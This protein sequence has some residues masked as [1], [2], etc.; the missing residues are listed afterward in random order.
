VVTDRKSDPDMSK[1][2]ERYIKGGR[3]NPAVRDELLRAY[4]FIV[5]IIANKLI[6]KLPYWVEVER[7]DLVSAGCFGLMDTLRTYDP[8]MGFKFQSFCGKRI[9]GAMIDDLRK[10]DWVPR[11]T[12]AR[13]RALKEAMEELRGKLGRDPTMREIKKRTGLEQKTIEALRN[14]DSRSR[15][16]S[17]QRVLSVNE[18]GKV[19]RFGETLADKRLSNL[20]RP[21]EAAEAKTF[22]DMITRGLGRRNRLIVI[23]YYLEELTMREVGL[24]LG[25]SESRV[26]QIHDTEILPKL[27]EML[28]PMA[29]ERGLVRA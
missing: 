21:F 13:A 14:V 8:S 17:L 26:S 6:G 15:V 1:V 12:R 2:W 9:R 29:K 27:R 24:I 25:V 10:R 18:R 16:V 4:L 23:L 11:V 20:N 28:L 19:L 22:V 5:E 7:G 3:K